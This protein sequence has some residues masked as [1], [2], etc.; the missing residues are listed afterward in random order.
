[1]AAAIVAASYAL[2]GAPAPGTYPASYPYTY[3]GGSYT[4]PGNAYTY[5]EGLNNITSGNDGTCAITY[6]CTAGPGYNGPTGLGSPNTALSLTTTGETGSF[7]AHLEV[8]ACLTWFTGGADI[9]GPVIASCDGSDTQNWTAQPNGTITINFGGGPLCLDLAGGGTASGT[10]VVTNPCS[11]AASQ[12]W[13]LTSSEEVVNAQS[14]LC[15]SGVNTADGT[16]V[17]IETCASSPAADQ[18]WTAPY[19]RPTASGAIK[20][21]ITSPKV[22]VD[23]TSDGTTNGNK[24]QIWSC[25]GDNA[26]NWTIEPDGTIRIDGKCLVTANN[27]TSNG[28][29]I[30]LWNCTGDT[31]QQWTERSDGTLVNTRSGTCLDDPH[32]TTTNGTQLQIWTCDGLVQQSW[33]LP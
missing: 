8:D 14:G 13:V 3:P 9:A 21:Q 31:N 22:C 20:S 32:A 18:Q 29:L 1:V 7:Q 23:D 28:T 10:A 15:M 12:Q 24:I 11:G 33:T 27:G 4:T 19:D 5:P 26:Q 25:L 30:N 17:E 6:E 2:A 16:E